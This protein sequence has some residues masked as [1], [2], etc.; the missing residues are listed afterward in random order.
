M[1]LFKWLR[2]RLIFQFHFCHHGASGTTFKYT[3]MSGTSMRSFGHLECLNPS[4][5]DAMGHC[6]RIRKNVTD[7]EQRT[8]NSQTENKLQGLALVACS[9]IKDGYHI[10]KIDASKIFW[11]NQ[12]SFQI[13]A[14]YLF[15]RLRYGLIFWFH[16]LPPQSQ[17]HHIQISCHVG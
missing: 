4:I 6:S 9:Q 7:R 2:Y 5:I 3:I 11:G 17:W 8:E 12:L 10:T 14:L 1:Q 16:F 13:S 15:K